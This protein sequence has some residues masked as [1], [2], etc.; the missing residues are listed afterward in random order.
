LEPEYKE[1]VTSEKMMML[2][3]IGYFCEGRIKGR[4]HNRY[5]E[6]PYEFTSFFM[7]I[8]KMEEI[9]DE[10]KF[11]GAF[12]SPRTFGVAKGGAKDIAKGIAQDVAK[13]GAKDIAQDGAQKIEVENKEAMQEDEK[14]VVSKGAAGSK[15]TFEIMVRY[16]QNATWQGQI[17]WLEKNQHQNF[18]SV[19]EMLKLMDE[20]LTEGEENAASVAWV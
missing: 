11:P 9:Y 4:L 6:A 5:L 16:R 18:R 3:E 20:A 19:L 14:E 7:M 10:K 15:C 2:A 1:I 8:E 17:H 13:G 12:L